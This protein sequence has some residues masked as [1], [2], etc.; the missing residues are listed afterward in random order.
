[1]NRSRTSWRRLLAVVSIVLGL[2]L[3]APLALAQTVDPRV[4]APSQSKALTGN[5]YEGWSV[6]WY[7]YVFAVP[8]SQNPLFD[9]KGDQCGVRQASNRV[10]FL[11][12][13]LN[14]SGTATRTCTVPAGKPLFFPV[15]NANNDNEGRDQALTQGQ[16]QAAVTRLVNTA[17]DLHASLDGTPIAVSPFYR[18]KSLNFTYTI[19]AT[20]NLYGI[21]CTGTTSPTCTGINSKGETVT[22]PWPDLTCT[23][24]PS[25][26]QSTCTAPAAADGYYLMLAPLSAGSHIL[27]FGGT[28]PTFP[29]TL[30]VTYT[31]KVQ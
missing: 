1:M 13:V 8:G 15:L 23:A 3:A 22:V 17:T 12:G 6:A 11:V 18:T 10:F 20:D 2:T 5:T 29:F 28:F 21:T 14:I 30:D 19:P 26:S 9:E 31:L 16:L 25:P 24:A 4:V 7:Q 27:N